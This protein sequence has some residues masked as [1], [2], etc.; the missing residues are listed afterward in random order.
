MIILKEIGASVK[1]LNDTIKEK[2]QRDR[3]VLTALINEQ[4]S[5]LDD[6]A[7]AQYQTLRHKIIDENGAHSMEMQDYTK[8]A[9]ANLAS[10]I[11]DDADTGLISIANAFV[12]ADS[13]LDALLAQSQTAKV[14]RWETRIALE[15]NYDGFKEGWDE[16]D[17]F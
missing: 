3:G 4:V 14:E 12:A 6:K 16:Y 15:G 13:D 2:K 11:V 7:V 8:E 17:R 1:D 10:I 9:K 5:E